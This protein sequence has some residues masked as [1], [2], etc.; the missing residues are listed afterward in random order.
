MNVQIKI[1]IA[2]D[3]QHI[4][5]SLSDILITKGYSVDTVK[6]G[7]ELLFYLRK[8]SPDILILDLMMPDKGGLEILSAVKCIAPHTR[9]IIYT[10]FE[11]YATS[12][13]S[14]M[15]DSFLLKDDDPQKLV[16]TIEDFA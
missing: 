7:Y 13:Y 8:N 1:V 4:R 16:D 5:E 11:R 15:A 14:E 10:G 9:V 12:S 2:D 6:D 3:N